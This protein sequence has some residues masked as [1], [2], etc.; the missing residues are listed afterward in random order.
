MVGDRS[1]YG[2]FV[3]AV[4]AIVLGVSVFLPWY[5]VGFAAHA[6]VGASAGGRLAT[7]S[8]FHALANLRVVFLVLAALAL[9]DALLPLASTGA[10]VP[11]GAGGSVVLLGTIAAACA[12][13]R[14]LELPA[15][16]G[17]VLAL[18]LREGAWL[19]L[20]GA[21]TMVLGG[22]WPRCV[23]SPAGSDA[24]APGAWSSGLSG[25]TVGG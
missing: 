12:L 24:D 19:A 15:L 7:V 10:P 18:S 2:L 17:E 3:S 20:L 8:A 25:W 13:F 5:G 21:V 16:T 9:L 14:M 4:G 1:R 11:G 22:M 6:G 23:Y